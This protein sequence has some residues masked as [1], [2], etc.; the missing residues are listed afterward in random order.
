MDQKPSIFQTGTKECGFFYAAIGA[1][2][3]LLLVF[4]GFW[5]ALL[6]AVFAAVGFSIGYIPEKSEKLKKK[7]NTLFPPKGE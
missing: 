6:V 5:R 3:A 2:L 4:L 7:I 1:V